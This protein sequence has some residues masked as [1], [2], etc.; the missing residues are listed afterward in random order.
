[1]LEAQGVQL[2]AA[3]AQ[4]RVARLAQLRNDARAALTAGESAADRLRRQGRASWAAQARLVAVDARQQMGETRSADLSMARRA[5]A[6]L[7]Q[8][9]MTSSAVDAYLS[10]GRGGVLGTGRGRRPRMD[11]GV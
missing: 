11:E 9:G 4:L 2:M 3:E 1:M 10:A 5:A 7:E 6:T 8:A